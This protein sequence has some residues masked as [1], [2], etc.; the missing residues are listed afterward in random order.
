MLPIANAEAMN[1]HLIAISAKVAPGAHAA[2]IMDNAGYHLAAEL[3]FP[4]NITPLP[5]PPYAPELNSMENVWEYRRGNKLSL[6]VFDDCDAILEKTCQ[7]WMFFA[8]DTDRI[9]SITNRDW[10]QV[11]H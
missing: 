8:N 5:L 7:A 6:T 11:N 4:E 9:Y 1:E 3:N 10:A 2:L